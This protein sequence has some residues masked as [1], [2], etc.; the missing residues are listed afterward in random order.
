MNGRFVDLCKNFANERKNLFRF[1]SLADRTS[2]S[3]TPL[4]HQHLYFSGCR[5]SENHFL[6]RNHSNNNS[7][8]EDGGLDRKLYTSPI[9]E[10]KSGV[11]L[12]HKKNEKNAKQ[13]EESVHCRLNNSDLYNSSTDE[14]MRLNNLAMMS[15]T[16]GSHSLDVGEAVWPVDRA[17]LVNDFSS[18]TYAEN[19]GVLSERS[20]HASDYAAVASATGRSA[21]C[22][23]YGS[24]M[25]SLTG[26]PR[27]A[28]SY[29]ANASGECPELNYD[30]YSKSALRCS[31]K[32]GMAD[33]F[34]RQ[35]IENS[36]YGGLV[37]QLVGEKNP[38]FESH[39]PYSLRSSSITYAEIPPSI[40]TTSSGLVPDYSMSAQY[41]EKSENRRLNASL[42][43]DLS[44]DSKSPN[45]L[46]KFSGIDGRTGLLDYRNSAGGSQRTSNYSSPVEM[47]GYKDNK[48]AKQVRDGPGMLVYGLDPTVGK[49]HQLTAEYTSQLPSPPR[50]ESAA[51][52]HNPSYLQHGDQP[53]E[54]LPP[55]PER[56]LCP[57]LPGSERESHESADDQTGFPLE[58]SYQQESPAESNHDELPQGADITKH[59]YV[60]NEGGIPVPAESSINL[61]QIHSSDQ[62]IHERDEEEE[63][64]ELTPA[65]QS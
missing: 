17:S 4:I 34:S 11:P 64:L 38:A 12:A 45:F 52:I 16:S 29:G 2:S 51:E 33:Q 35:T 55:R 60:K 46:S 40:V 22:S 57:S 21:P 25:S 62:S 50:L 56:V 30:S 7:Y 8:E 47:P 20:A 32:Y 58:S 9:A 49:L 48:S 5:T 27:S 23:F 28:L 53:M 43:N 39:S 1:S 19:N 63:E 24:T 42:Y 3:S 14:R 10:M 31:S 61:P 54:V 15:S 36:L 37:Q 13:L 26:V 65:S 44:S 18:T 59:I 41:L 6:R